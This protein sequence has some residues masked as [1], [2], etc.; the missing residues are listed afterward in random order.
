MLLRC[1]DGLLV[2]TRYLAWGLGVLGV[3]VSATLFCLNLPLG[4]ASALVWI[5]ALLLAVGVTLTLL[6]AALVRGKLAG[7]LRWAVGCGALAA[8]VLLWVRRNMPDGVLS[9]LLLALILVE[10]GSIIP[11]IVVLKQRLNEIEG[12]EEDAAAQ[13]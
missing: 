2:G 13:Y 8:A 12:G 5:A 11:T 6:P 3:V 9:T 1:I 4:A 10:L 7:K